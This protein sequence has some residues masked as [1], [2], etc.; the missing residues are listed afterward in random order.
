MLASCACLKDEAGQH[1][2]KMLSNLSCPEK[3]PP[4]LKFWYL[5]LCSLDQVLFLLNLHIH[6]VI[7]ELCFQGSILI[8]WNL[9][10]LA[11]EM[12]SMIA[13]CWLLHWTNH[14]NS[15]T[16]PLLSYLQVCLRVFTFNLSLCNGMHIDCA[17]KMNI[18]FLFLCRGCF[19]FNAIVISAWQIL[20]ISIVDMLWAV[21]LL[22]R[23]IG[24]VGAELSLKHQVSSLSFNNFLVV[25][26][27]VNS[28][29]LNLRCWNQ[30]T[31][32]HFTCWLVL[33]MMSSLFISF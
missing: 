8:K 16:L 31:N 25:R 4:T 32:V 24:K 1:C 27:G 9:R 22:V 19:C 14:G 30:L 12:S 29:G 28:L 5:G 18:L 3:A 13:N 20:K 10:H 21:Q 2:L 23:L 7:T 11:V 33:Y 15:C 17:H 6:C 26:E